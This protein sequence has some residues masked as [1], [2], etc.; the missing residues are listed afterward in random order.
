MSIFQTVLNRLRVAAQGR[1]NIENKGRLTTD[2]SNGG[3]YMIP[4][5]VIDLR[6]LL[7]DWER[8]D[9]ELRKTHAR[10][11]TENQLLY[12]GKLLPTKDG[13]KIGNAVVVTSDAP[14]RWLLETDFG[15]TLRLS[16]SELDSLFHLD[17]EPE[18]D[19]QPRTLERWF[20]DRL[21]LVTKPREVEQ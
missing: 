13:R 11:R 5:R 2:T 14:D 6:M 17:F 8:L 21:R 1:D 10:P 20:A 16:Y 7:D 18:I 9:R 19:E 12:P 15:N 3:I 4:V